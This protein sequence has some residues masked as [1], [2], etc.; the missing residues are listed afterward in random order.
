MTK[1]IICGNEFEAAAENENICPACK[2]AATGT[3]TPAKEAPK[4][5]KITPGAH[6]TTQYLID[7]LNEKGWHYRTTLHKEEGQ[8]D[9]VI[10]PMSSDNLPSIPVHCFFAAE[11]E[12]ISTFVYN[13]HKIPED[14]LYIVPELISKLQ[15]E[16]MFAR[17]KLDA[18]DNT[19]QAEWYGHTT[20]GPETGEICLTSVKRLTSVVDNCFPI[21]MQILYSAPPMQK[22]VIAQKDNGV[23]S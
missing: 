22:K 4:V 2:Q 20:G 19:L 13:V 10:I 16:Y 15:E 5:E 7:L 8:S 14:R 12:R 11:G 17:W 9:R 18:N 23:V 3:E 1:C 6:K 21:I